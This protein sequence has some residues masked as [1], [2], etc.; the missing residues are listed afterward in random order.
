MHDARQRDGD[1]I[2]RL[3]S[4]ELSR[5]VM[6]WKLCSKN[7]NET[8]NIN[9]DIINIDFTLTQFTSGHINIESMGLPI[10]KVVILL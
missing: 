2:S 5:H 7:N 6:C 4:S 9:S 8:F 10:I 1:L 3:E